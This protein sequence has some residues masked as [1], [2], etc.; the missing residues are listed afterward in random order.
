M[1]NNSN[2]SILFLGKKNDTHSLRAIEFIKSNFDNTTVLLGDWGEPIPDKMLN[3]KGDFIISYLSRWVIPYEVLEKAKI[4]AINFHP[5]SPDYPGIGCNNF[6]LYNEEKI[7]GVTCHHMHR[8]VDTGPIVSTKSFPIYPNDSVASLLSRTYDFQLILFYEM[9][10]KI[11]NKNSL[12][13]SK[14]AWSRKPFTRKEFNKLT[15]IKPGMGEKEIRKRIRATTFEGWQDKKRI[16]LIGAGGHAKSCIEVIESTNE[17]VIHGLVDNSEDIESVLGY[18]HI[19]SDK[20]LEKIKKD[21]ENAIVTVGQ[22]KT[23]GLREKLYERLIELG[24]TTP[25]IISPSAY[26]SQHSKIGS[27]SIVMNSSIVNASAVIGLNCILN[28]NSLIEH[29]AK[30]GDHCHISTGA[31]INGGAKIG[32]NTFIGSGSVIKQGVKIGNNCLISA[33]LFIEDDTSDGQILR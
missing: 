23:S 14:E 32:K 1:N 17:F 6:A 15:K 19:G 9:L 24:F 22:I 8:T 3:W 25:R 12:P 2:K 10:S 28:N 18:A 31:I 30:I 26:V 27:G 4:A 33:G 29:D 21:T 11:L 20:E 5:A 7:F 13:T 16:V